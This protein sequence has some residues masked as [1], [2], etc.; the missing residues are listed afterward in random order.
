MKTTFFIFILNFLFASLLAQSNSEHDSISVKYNGIYKGSPV[1][2]VGSGTK[3]FTGSTIVGNTVM[4]TYRIQKYS[5][6]TC[7]PFFRFYKDGTVLFYVSKHNGSINDT[8]DFNDGNQLKKENSSDS[9]KIKVGLHRLFFPPQGIVRGKYNINN[10][11]I[12]FTLGMVKFIGQIKG[13]KII[14]TWYE[15]DYVKRIHCI[16]LD[17]KSKVVFIPYSNM[18]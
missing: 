17:D 3:Q 6:Y 15:I 18:N 2:N 10:K 16:G 7:T 1:F 4:N 8:S 5:D 14:F 13:N 12:T 9:I 11:K